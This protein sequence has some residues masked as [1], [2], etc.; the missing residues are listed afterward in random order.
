[1]DKL[2]VT[3]KILTPLFLG[4]AEPRG[5]PPE[6]RV[7]SLRGALRYWYRT[8]I[9][10]ASDDTSLKKLYDAESAIFGNTKQASSVIIRAQWL[11]GEPKDESFN[12]NEFKQG[13]I[14]PT[15]K[16]RTSGTN[17]LLW[18]MGPLGGSARKYYLP[19]ENKTLELA[20][21]KRIGV[22]DGDQKL[23]EAGFALWLLC[24]LGG[25]GSR[26]RRTAGSLQMVHASPLKGLPSF[27]APA[28]VDS[29]ASHLQSGIQEIRKHF[30]KSTPTPSRQYDV[31]SSP[32]CKIW[33]IRGEQL[34]DNWK[35]AV[36]TIGSYFCG[37]RNER[38][39]DYPDVLNW[40][41]GK[42]TPNT[43]QR[44]VFGLPLPFRYSNG[45]KGTVVGTIH[46]DRRASPLHL[47][48]YQLSGGEHVCIAT[49][50]MTE[51]L[52]RDERGNTEKLKLQ[53]K[54]RTPVTAPSDY[55][56]IEEFIQSI[57]P[58]PIEVTL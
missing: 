39:T 33:I 8:A 24:H 38:P 27:T 10:G 35:L 26:A 41:N 29:L 16:C 36:E 18:S 7:P 40:I 32:T 49:L 42:S 30:G 11:N 4:G 31:I 51:F 34:W 12:P 52:D 3:L 1:M 44:A 55:Q 5:K 58:T 17:Y 25:I 6:L 45:T 14:D 56:L 43:V 57:S 47:R 19:D 50:F 20:L 48:I 23:L 54:N 15:E 21:E 22:K 28:T 37:F 13:K 53:K 9:G 2:T 46:E